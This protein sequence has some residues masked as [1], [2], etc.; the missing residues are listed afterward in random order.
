[1][2]KRVMRFLSSCHK[3]NNNMF[4]F[5]C[6]VYQEQM[7]EWAPGMVLPRKKAASADDI[8]RGNEREDVVSAEDAWSKRSRDL[9]NAKQSKISGWY[10]YFMLLPRKPSKP[11]F[12]FSFRCIIV[13]EQQFEYK[14]FKNCFPHLC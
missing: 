1:M 3:I 4:P 5:S 10:N 6:S 13:V 12:L 11:Y 9:A 7:R 8:I 2:R 14:R